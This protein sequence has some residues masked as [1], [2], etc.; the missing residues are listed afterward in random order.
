MAHII[1]PASLPPEFYDAWRLL[2]SGVSGAHRDYRD[3]LDAHRGEI[4]AM[5][6]RLGDETTRLG[7][8]SRASVRDLGGMI[9]VL[10]SA[11]FA[12][13]AHDEATQRR[14]K[15]QDAAERAQSALTAAQHALEEAN[16]LAAELGMGDDESDDI[17]DRLIILSAEWRARG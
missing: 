5:A 13:E 8:P 11:E 17:L 16:S 10:E 7:L 6:Y 15:A 9:A 4:A 1:P 2:V 14:Q 12:L 3:L